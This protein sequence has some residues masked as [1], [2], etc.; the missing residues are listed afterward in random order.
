MIETDILIV[1]G[2][3]A[4][5]TLATY[6]S[7]SHISNIILQR[8]LS[9]NK[10][11]G[12]GI[13]L[14]TF[15]EFEIDKKIIKKNVDTIVLVFKSQRI[16]VD[17]S[18]TPIAIVERVEFDTHLRNKAK[19]SG[20]VLYEATFVSVEIFD[21][22]VISTMK[23]EGKYF[24]I[25]SRYLIAADGVNSK[26]RRIVNGDEVY[27]SLT[28]YTDIHSK[29]Y[30]NCEF[31]F[32]EEVADKYYAWAFPHADGS[33]IGTLAASN[34]NYIKRLK[35]N[36]EIDETTII[37]GY[38]IPHFKNNIF[39]KNRVFFVGD[40]ASEVLPFTY[41][42]IYYA[43]SSA[44]ILADVLIENQ[45]PSE[46]EKRWNKKY[47]KKFHTLAL[48]QNIFLRNNFMISIMMRL[49]QNKYIQQQMV[50]FWLGKREVTVDFKFF[51]RVLKRLIK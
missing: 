4:G 33:N 6:L 10:P 7:A 8:N 23:K 45:E 46:Y 30:T 51:M 28:H 47:Y 18:G 21:T 11:C 12:G 39:Y 37:L 17:I 20:T 25:K 5:A 2:G 19:E 38:K 44:K 13:R 41:E 27:S 22:Y 15:D 24:K 3:P 40:S 1:G 35:V 16:E 42:G 43:M 34:Q 32:G 48:L 49:Y 31:H 29:Q 14:D 9:F 50:E 26:I 36:L